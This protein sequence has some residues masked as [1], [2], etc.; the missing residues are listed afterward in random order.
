MSYVRSF[1]PWIAYAA[2]SAV[3]DWRIAAGCALALAVAGVLADRRRFGDVDD[4]TVA[5]AGGFLALWALSLL[6]PSSPVHR[7]TPALSLT[8]LG[9]AAAVSLL[10]RAPFTLTIAKR[11]VA[12]ELWGLPAFLDAN[13]VITS[14]WA[15]S[16]LVTAALCAAILAVA[17][18]ATA[19]WVAVEVV[20]FVV[21]VRF[22]TRYRAQVRSRMASSTTPATVATAE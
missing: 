22:T 8:L 12:P 19:A 16:L 15:A 1:A 21:P 7:F 20:G 2:V 9:G 18:A 6:D 11:T 14:V 13:T 3:A 4:L 10:R 17:P 5:T